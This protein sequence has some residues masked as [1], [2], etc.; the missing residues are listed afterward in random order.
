MLAIRQF[1]DERK[2]WENEREVLEARERALSTEKEEAD[3]QLAFLHEEIERLR[4]SQ[5][6]APTTP[7]R[8]G[9]VEPAE[10][11]RSRHNQQLALMAKLDDL[12]RDLEQE[13]QRSRMFEQRA[14]EA[15]KQN[16]RL[17][18]DIDRGRGERGG[19][20]GGSDVDL[21]LGSSSR[22]HFQASYTSGPGSIGGSGESAPGDCQEARLSLEA[23]RKEVLSLEDETLRLREELN[24]EKQ[25]VIQLK[26]GA[27]GRAAAW[28]EELQKLT[29]ELTQKQRLEEEVSQLRRE[30]SRFRKELGQVSEREVASRREATRLQQELLEA[31]SEKSRAHNTV[32]EKEQEME[33]L[34][35]C[36]GGQ[37]VAVE[38]ELTNQMKKNSQLF[39]LFLEKAH[40]PLTG[41]RRSCRK[42]AASGA[43]GRELASRQVP[44]LFE[45]NVH[46]LQTNL[47]KIID[48]LRFSTEVLEARDVREEQYAQ[49][50]RQQQ[51]RPQSSG[52]MEDTARS[53]MK[54]FMAQ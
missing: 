23:T 26:R 36:V 54:P 21:P 46:D 1:Q 45:V 17:S 16:R 49:Q 34:S 10:Q 22:R 41:L 48:L 37:L 24:N 19:S 18:M 8:Q 12:R 2:E 53:W 43:S 38:Q 32:A 4:S 31:R 35:K 7:V 30:I 13:Q 42:I 28:K 51:Q 25:K 5:A 15:E 11:V 47:A 3:A 44:V 6:A 40:E 14:A 50:R 20:L 52:V 27:T 29:E 39:E 9:P 33:I